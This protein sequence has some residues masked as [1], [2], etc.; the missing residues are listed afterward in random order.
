MDYSDREADE[1]R[2]CMF[3]RESCVPTYVRNVCV[4]CLCDLEKQKQEAY[5]TFSRFRDLL[6]RSHGIR[7][8]IVL[9]MAVTWLAV[10]LME[11]LL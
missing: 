5:Q 8:T 1:E 11:S 4:D 2:I 9:L 10:T 3:C 7:P 6:D